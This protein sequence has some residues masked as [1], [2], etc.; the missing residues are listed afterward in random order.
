MS[1]KPVV[2]TD[3]TGK[4]YDNALRFETKEEALLSA[5]DLM[6]RWL[7]VLACDAQESE[8]PVN[9]RLVDGQLEQV[10]T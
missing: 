3:R 6:N 10:K 4:W 8:D 7:S 1:W 9:Y 5:C 2:Q